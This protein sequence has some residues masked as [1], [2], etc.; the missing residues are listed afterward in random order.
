MLA[1][2]PD[3]E[4]RVLEEISGLDTDLAASPEAVDRLVYTRQVVLEVMR[5][6]PPAPLIVR[7]ATADIRLGDRVVKAGESVHVPVCAVHRHVLLWDRPQLLNP[8]RFDPE[9]AASRDRYA[10]LP[11]G[12]GP[13]VCI[14][15]GLALTECLVIL[16]RLLPAF[17]FVPATVEMPTAPFRVTLRPKGGMRM[18][19][20]PRYGL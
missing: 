18:K 14:G 11:F 9:A 16:A 3:V 1:E 7:R 12:A 20:V 2:H 4:R 5:L 13:R 10:F 19:I 6:Y 8:D 17:R 15:M